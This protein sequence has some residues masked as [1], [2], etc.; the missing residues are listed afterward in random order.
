MNFAALLVRNSG[1]ATPSL[2][3]TPKAHHPNQ[4]NPAETHLSSARSCS[5]NPSQLC[6]TR[7]RSARVAYLQPME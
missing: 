2:R 7:N 1:R 4:G 6:V 5:D 3:R